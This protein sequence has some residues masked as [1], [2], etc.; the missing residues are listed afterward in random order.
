MDEFSHFVL[1]RGVMAGNS[2]LTPRHFKLL[3]YIRDNKYS[4]EE[5]SKKSGF[6]E[7]YISDLL[8]G[9]V[10]KTGIVGQKF[11]SE[12]KKVDEEVESRISRKTHFVRE[13]LMNKLIQWIDA[14]G[15]GADLDTKTKHKQLVD[16]INAVS[17]T[18]P[19]MVNVNQFAWKEGMSAEEAINEFK[20]LKAM[21]E[22][23]VVR[24]RIQELVPGGSAEGVISDRPFDEGFEDAQ[25]S[26]LQA[27]PETTPIP[28]EQVSGEGDIRGE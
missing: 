5:L 14:A 1:Y 4:Y 22:K 6:D 9:N 8:H 12:L 2:D 18:M 28:P 27:T 3:G 15:G 21:A 20:R 17:K 16:A 10:L 11:M 13:K 25:D 23:S 24:R 19:Y 7:A 26:L